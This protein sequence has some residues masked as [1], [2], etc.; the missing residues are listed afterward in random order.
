LNDIIPPA[1]AWQCCPPIHH[2]V[3]MCVEF[4]RHRACLGN[5]V[6]SLGVTHI[7]MLREKGEYRDQRFRTYR[8]ILSGEKYKCQQSWQNIS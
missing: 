6:E 2:V 4:W 8:V 7:G 5:H 1:N 3:E